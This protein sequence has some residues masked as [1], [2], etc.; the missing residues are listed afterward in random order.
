[1]I[2]YIENDY[3]KIGVKEYGCELTSVILKENNSF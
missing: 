2:H 1:M 3:L